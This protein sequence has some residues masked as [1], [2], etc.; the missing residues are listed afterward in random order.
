MIAIPDPSALRRAVRE[1]RL[2]P[3]PDYPRAF[4]RFTAW[5]VLGPAVGPQDLLER[6]RAAFAIGDFGRSLRDAE[7]AAVLRP[8]DQAAHVQKARAALA[9]AAVRCEVLPVGP[10]LPPPPDLD[11]GDL[12]R[13]ARDAL[14]D[15]LRVEPADAEVRRTADIAARLLDGMRAGPATTR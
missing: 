7:E 14:K 10:G 5:A 9:L 6:S 8:R 3:D 11:A 4:A 13:C 1:L 15:A 12:V 2:E